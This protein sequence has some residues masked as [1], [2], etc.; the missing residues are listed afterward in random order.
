[1]DAFDKFWFFVKRFFFPGFLILAGLWLIILAVGQQAASKIMV[2][3]GEDPSNTLT[4][5][6]YFLYGAIT[7]LIVGVI[8]LYFILQKKIPSVI[9]FGLAGVALLAAVYLTIFNWNSIEERIIYEAQW[10]ES[11]NLAKQGLEDIQKLQEAH[12]KNYGGF[13]PTFDSLITFAQT[14]SI[15]VLVKAEGDLPSRKMTLDEAKKLGYRFPPEIWTEEDAIK[16]GLIIREYDKVPVSEYLFSK[17]K[18]EK[19]S[20]LYPFDLMS[21]AQQRTI[22]ST[23]KTFVIETSEIDSTTL[24]VR[25]LAV[26]PYGPQVPNDIE[27]TLQIGSLTELKMNTNWR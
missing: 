19:E 27:D 21:I 8:S 24:G 10:A 5:T 20:R 16:L 23:K 26:P 7:L 17:E 3:A 18:L 11:E 1:M 25:I 2:A 9:V 12:K 6:T 15:S 13:A 4:Q 14:D 22:D